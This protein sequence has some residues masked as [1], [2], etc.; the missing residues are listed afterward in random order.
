MRQV[1]P[2]Y[3]EIVFK[4][5]IASITSIS[6]EHEEK[7]FDGEVSGDFIIFGDYKVHKDTTEKEL[8][9]Y[10]L[11]FTALIPDEV[12]KNTIKVDIDNFT[13]EQIEDDVIK[14]NID[15]SIEGEKTEVLVVDRDEQ[16]DLT[17]E[18]IDREINELLGLDNDCDEVNECCEMLESAD[19]EEDNELENEF[20]VD[21]EVLDVPDVCDEETVVIPEEEVDEER[22][23]VIMDNTGNNDNIEVNMNDYEISNN[24]LT[25]ASPKE[26][27]ENELENIEVVKKE[28]A[29][30]QVNEYVTYHVHIVRENDTLESIIKTYNIS[31]EYLKEYN[32][33]T[34]LKIG[35]KLIIPEYGE[36]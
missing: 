17:D 26:S 5:N 36:E 16:R 30:E 25:F 34:D 22:D 4:T 24:E 8:F 35:D 11:P 7:V 3:K 29:S 27:N 6:L 9:K 20:D 31:I 19:I 28:E 10:R 1:I 21:L 32:E 12:D 23:M 14:V 15:F 18:E 2:F 13:Y 33:V